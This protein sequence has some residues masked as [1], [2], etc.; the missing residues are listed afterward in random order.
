MPRLALEGGGKVL[1]M[2]V[3]HF[4]LIRGGVGLPYYGERWRYR[5]KICIAP[6][7]FN[8]LHRSGVL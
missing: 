1:E 8:A 2:T 5:E 6:Q 4:G 7:L 3:A